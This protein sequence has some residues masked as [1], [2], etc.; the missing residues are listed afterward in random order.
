MRHPYM[1][2]DALVYAPAPDALGAEFADQGAIFSKPLRDTHD[3]L[4]WFEIADPDG[5]V[6]F[7]GRPTE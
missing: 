5:Y 2:R 4:R 7:F 1:R 3:G 6:L